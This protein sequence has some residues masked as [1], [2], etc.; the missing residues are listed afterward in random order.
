MVDVS[1]WLK[2]GGRGLEEGGGGGGRER[3][4]FSFKTGVR[5]Q[6]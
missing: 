4:T 2:G 6:V 1:L 5:T 3:K